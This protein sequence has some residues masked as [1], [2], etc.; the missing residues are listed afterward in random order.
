M[1]KYVIKRKDVCAGELLR[2]DFLSF[3]VFDANHNEITIEELN[4][5]GIEFSVSGG[6]ICRGML[7]NVNENNLAK[8]LIYTTPENYVIEGIEPK[9]EVES[10]F[11][12]QHYV[13]L[14]E[15]LKYLK[16]GEDLTQRDL[17]KIYRKLITHNR[18]LK[19]H[20]KLFGYKKLAIGYG[21]DG[22]NQT[23]PREIYDNLDNISCFGIG[24]P[25]KEE[26]NYRSIRR[27]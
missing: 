24:K 17:N 19:H 18:W 2:K 11:I 25:Y 27:R 23:L 5:Q 13:E 1:S 21:S 15:L 12:I 9:I 14:E 10:D 3:K 20:M 26:P 16:F 7:F 6:I 22:S 4:N 8:D